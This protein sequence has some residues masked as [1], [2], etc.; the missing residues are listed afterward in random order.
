MVSF[1]AKVHNDKKRFVIPIRI[2][3]AFGWGR[4]ARVGLVIFGADGHCKF[5]GV[6]TM[7][8]GPEIYGDEMSNCLFE[9][10]QIFAY[11]FNPPH[12]DA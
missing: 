10:E 3:K 2:R 8:S 4:R 7:K 11:A 6:Q 9:G 1:S 12:E 5:W